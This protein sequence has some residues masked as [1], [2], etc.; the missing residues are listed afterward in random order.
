MNSRVKT[1]T[2]G[3]AGF[4]LIVIGLLSWSYKNFGPVGSTRIFWSPIVWMA[5]IL[6]L[7]LM[8]LYYCLLKEAT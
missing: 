5:G 4:A 1:A 3:L 8:P 6:V 7:L 2:V